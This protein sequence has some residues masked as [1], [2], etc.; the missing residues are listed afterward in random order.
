MFHS[1][2]SDNFLTS[3]S[4]SVPLWVTDGPLCR[5]LYAVLP[6]L[7]TLA[8]PDPQL[9]HFN[10]EWPLGPISFPVPWH[11]PKTVQAISQSDHGP[12]SC[13]SHLSESIAIHCLRLVSWELLAHA[14][15][16]VLS[17]FRKE[18]ESSLCYSI[19]AG[20]VNHKIC[21]LHTSNMSQTSP[22]S[23]NIISLHNFLM[24]AKYFIS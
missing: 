10:S 15:C 17:C 23:L 13:A 4:C 2:A 3:V 22:V 12:A 9:R 5:Y 20:N 21:S 11:S 8:F 1:L 24:T 6:K 14:F 18:D 7:I 16:P 19:L